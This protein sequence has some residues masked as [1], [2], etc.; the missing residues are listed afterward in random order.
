MIFALLI[1]EELLS[2]TTQ[3]AELPSATY[4][5]ANLS[6]EPLW[7]AFFGL[8]FGGLLYWLWKMKI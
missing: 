5:I 2:S 6:P 3:S 8:V 4:H 1:V 7:Q